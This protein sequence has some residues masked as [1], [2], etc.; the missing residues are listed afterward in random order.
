MQNDEQFE[1]IAMYPTN[2]SSQMPTTSEAESPRIGVELQLEAAS[3]GIKRDRK[4]KSSV[5]HYFID[6]GPNKKAICTL[7]NRPYSRYPSTLRSH[8]ERFHKDEFVDRVPEGN[9]IGSATLNE[10]PVPWSQS[11]EVLPGYAVKEEPTE[12]VGG[13]QSELD[14]LMMNAIQDAAAGI[15]DLPPSPALGGTPPPAE[16]RRPRK[17]KSNVWEFFEYNALDGKAVCTLCQRS[18]S[19][20]TS[21]M[22]QHLDH[23]HKEEWNSRLCEEGSDSAGA[24]AGLQALQDLFSNNNTEDPLENQNLSEEAQESLLIRGAQSSE[25]SELLQTASRP[26]IQPLQATAR[27]I[28]KSKRGRK[29]NSTVWDYFE[30]NAHSEKAVC[31]FCNRAYSKY[32]STLR[33]HLERCHASMLKKPRLDD[34]AISSIFIR[35]APS[36]LASSPQGSGQEPLHALTDLFANTSLPL[37]L[38]DRP[39]FRQFASLLNPAFELPDS[40]Q[41]QESLLQQ[42]G[43]VKRRICD[44]ILGS[45]GVSLSTAIWTAEEHGTPFLSVNAHFVS[46]EKGRILS[47]LLDMRPLPEKYCIDD[48]VEVL[49]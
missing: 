25:Q 19:K 32:P 28:K 31:T 49:N 12:T 4:N 10:T 21:T 5:W 8:L 42:Y 48:V 2:G 26:R 47:P 41:L 27:I 18:Y 40:E 45:E 9:N 20:Y 36:P 14:R 15:A 34:R 1:N 11:L 46:R 16:A 13:E 30:Y 35:P 22:R 3:S 29:R 33:D 7:C 37:A 6:G 44:A 39:E 43:D 38:V 17:N 23:F 24:L